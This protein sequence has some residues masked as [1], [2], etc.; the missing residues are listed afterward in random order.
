MVLEKYPGTWIVTD[1]IT[2]EGLTRFIEKELGG[3]HHR[4]KRG[5]RNVI[6]EAIRLNRE[7][8]ECHLAIETSGHAAMK[9]NHWLD[10]GAFLV[11]FLLAKMAR[12]GRENK[13][14]EDLIRRL[15]HPREEKE[16]RIKVLAADFASYGQQVLDDL[17][18][19]V[20]KQ[21]GWQV[22]HPNYEGVRVT[23]DRE[24]GDGWFLLRLSLHDPVLPLNAESNTTGGI[25]I[26]MKKLKE[27][28][29]KYDKLDISI[30]D[31]F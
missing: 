25:H 22:V 20:E 7:G 14:L 19:F 12:L 27:F 23:C 26:M 2:S 11:S 30:P 13:T 18:S 5:Y 8:K 1:S 28:L 24:H 9:E 17:V 31:N 15:E 16:F 29:K 3:H 10:D 21:E 4:F 6:N